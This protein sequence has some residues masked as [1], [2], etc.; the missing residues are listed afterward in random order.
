MPLLEG[1]GVE[2]GSH[3]GGWVTWAH[4]SMWR[5]LSWVLQGVEQHP[6]PLSVG[7]RLSRLSPGGTIALG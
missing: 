2:E 7:P 1:P 6:R 3:H 5:G 4:Y